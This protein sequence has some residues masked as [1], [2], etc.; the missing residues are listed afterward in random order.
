MDTERHLLFGLLALRAGLI[1]ARPLAGAWAAWSAR[2]DRSLADL[3]VERGHL[4]R[5]DRAA[6]EVLLERETTKQDRKSPGLSAD[7]RVR[8]ALAALDEFEAGDEPT[9]LPST[10]PSAEVLPPGPAPRTG[11]RYALIRECEPPTHR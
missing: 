7:E 2:P 4:T 3:L 11:D 6:V 10:A 8:R 5:A 1:Q 9:R